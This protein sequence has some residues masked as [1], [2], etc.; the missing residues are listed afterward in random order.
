MGRDNE[1]T[2]A[3]CSKLFTPVPYVKQDQAKGECTPEESILSR[4]RL[5]RYC[6]V[7]KKFDIVSNLKSRRRTIWRRWC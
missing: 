3:A 4:V 6:G 2:A 7:Y 1:N 5:L